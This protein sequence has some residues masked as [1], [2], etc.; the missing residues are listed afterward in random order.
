M[1]RGNA[2]Q[3]I[4]FDAGDRTRFFLLLQESVERFDYRVH[5]FCL[6]T[7]HLHLA[8]QV[9]QIPLSRIMQ[10]VG[11]RYTQFINRKYQRSG[12][13][14]QGRYKALLIDG[15]GYLLELIRY[16][17]LNPIRSGMV[18]CPEEYR[19]SSH[20]NYLHP[21]SRPPWLTVDWGLSRF[22]D[23]TSEAVERYKRFVELDL[24]E[25]HREEFHRGSYE[26][27]A[28]GD[29]HFVEQALSKADEPCPVVLKLDQILA[30]VCAVYHLTTAEFCAPGRAQPAAEARALAAYLVRRGSSATLSELAAYVQ[31][32]LSGLSQAARRIERRMAAD[33]TLRR[34]LVKVEELLE[35]SV[36]QA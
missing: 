21:I 17:H 20:V 6:M 14:F 25:G 31:R 28:L 23:R 7:N 10:N 29:D 30:S 9:G 22:A 19:W 1:L 12:H 24:E 8:L 5:A 26:G 18:R 11:F 16:L 35:N 36:C 32:D 34:K 3:D 27:R 2:G 15:D 13:L 4:F 33:D